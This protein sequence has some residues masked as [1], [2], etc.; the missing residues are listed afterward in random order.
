MAQVEFSYNGINTIVQCNL[1]E[2]M[3]DICKKFKDKAQIGNKNIFYTYDGKIGIHE[4]LTFE[5]IANR[6]DKGRSKMNIIVFEN[7]FEINTNDIIKSKNIICPDCKENIKMDIKDYKINLYKCKN[8]HKFENILLNE[9]EETQNIDLSNIICDICKTNNKSKTFNNIF[10]KCLTCN[11]NVCPLCKSSHEEQHKIIDYDD[12][13]YICEMH[14]ENYISYCEQCKLNLCIQCEGHKNH[15]RIFYSDILPK[16]EKLLNKRYELKDKIYLFNNDIKMIINILNEVMNN[17]NYYYM[18][19]ESLI[20]NYDDSNK[21]RNYETI[22]YLN[23][24]Q[25]NNYIDELSKIIE[26][27]NIKEKFNKIFYI[28]RKMNLDEI[29]IIYK[30]KEKEVKL[31]DEDFVKNNKNNCKLVINGKEQELKEKYTFGLFTTKKDI[32]EIKLKGITNI[33]NAS[34]MFYKCSS[35]TSLPNISKWNTS[36]VTDMSSMFYKCSSLSSLPDISKW[37]TSNVTNMSCMFYDCFSLLSLP[38]ISKWNTSNVINMVGMF[39]ACNDS[40]NIPSKFKK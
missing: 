6:E 22:Y 38:D 32:L 16:K 24:F 30:V 29:N 3:K 17:I 27:N 34:C 21:N 9:F 35:L 37:N 4:E 19:N 25:K 20:N 23:Q 40:L 7:E 26:C 28:Y 2:K 36:N 13:Y 11:K 31:F 8:G 10:Y 5:E 14:N 33:T 1:D 15:Q 39:Y 18:I 12:K